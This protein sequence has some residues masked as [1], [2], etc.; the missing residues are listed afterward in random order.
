MT[1]KFVKQRLRES[2]PYIRSLREERLLENVK[3]G[4]LF[5][6]VECDIEVNDKLRGTFAELPP[7]FKNSNIGRDDNGPFLKEYAKKEGLLTQP[8]KMLI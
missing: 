5:G 2:F 1:D 6:Y 4:S 7:I 8:R 3:N